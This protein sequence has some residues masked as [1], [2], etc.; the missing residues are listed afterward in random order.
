MEEAAALQSGATLQDGKY[1]IVQILGQGGFG[2]T[3]EAEQV[4][5]N[6][7]V[8]IV[9]CTDGVIRNGS[10]P[11]ENRATENRADGGCG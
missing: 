8:A 6:R 9:R 1:R 2:I 5:L 11:N 10:D 4:A 3:Y 7:R